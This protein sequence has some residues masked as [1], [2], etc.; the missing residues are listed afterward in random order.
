M[1]KI[2]SDSRE[3]DVWLFRLGWIAAAGAL[4]VGAIGYA[5]G[6]N[7]TGGHRFGSNIVPASL[8]GAGILIFLSLAWGVIRGAASLAFLTR[9]CILGL[10]GLCTL[11]ALAFLRNVKPLIL[12]RADLAMGSESQFVDQIIRYRAG[13]PQYTPG[14]DGNSTAY[15][16]GAPMLTYWLQGHRQ[17]GFHPRVPRDAVA[18]CVRGR[19]ALR[20]GHLVI[21][22]I[23][24]AGESEPVLVGAVLA[25]IHAVDGHQPANERIHA[26]AV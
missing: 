17:A 9:L 11:Q 23:F 1:M 18:V 3:L 12:L 4:V 6:W 25:A 26:G 16:P 15:S 24:A 8:F 19:R 20:M 5:L 21:G 13:A 14:E 22:R 10:A 2:P 7:T